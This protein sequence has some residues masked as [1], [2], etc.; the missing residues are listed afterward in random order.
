[1]PQINN[2]MDENKNVPTP[3]ELEQ[4][5]KAL[6]QAKEEE[7]RSSVIEEFGFDEEIDTDKIDKAV[8][9]EMNNRKRL[10]EAIGQ[11]INYRKEAEKL[12]NVIPPTKPD[13]K[14]NGKAEALNLKD[15]RALQD[16]HDDD[17]D[18]VVEFAKFK[19]ISIAEAKKT[20]T[21]QN[22]LRAKEEERTTAQAANTGQSKRSSSKASDE[23]LLDKF[24]KG[25]LPAEDIEKAVRA[26]LERKRQGLK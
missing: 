2:P 12:R 11:K 7:V 10:S 19:G 18:E 20:P 9:K 13:V 3:E 6:K 1:M 22:L 4:E 17:V 24:S 5:Q 14:D 23:S 15:I 26:R 21:M 8:A 16:V 25:E